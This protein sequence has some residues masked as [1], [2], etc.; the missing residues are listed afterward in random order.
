MAR[1]DRWQTC[2]CALAMVGALAGVDAQ[3]AVVINEQQR[4][5]TIEGF[6]A[7]PAHDQRDFA[8]PQAVVASAVNDLGLSILRIVPYPIFQ[9]T[10]NSDTGALDMSRYNLSAPHVVT[11]FQVLRR[12]AAA[13]MTRVFM[14]VFTPPAW[15]KQGPFA[16]T[17]TG[18]PGECGGTLRPD[19]YDVFAMYYAAWIKAIK[20]ETGIDVY[21]I[22]PENEPAWQQWY[23]SCVYSPTQMRDVIKALGRRFEREGIRTKII[24]AEDVITNQPYNYFGATM[25]DT[26]AARYMQ[27]LALHAYENNGVTPTSPSAA[28]WSGAYSRAHPRGKAIWMTET[29]GYANTWAD[30]LKYGNGIYTALKYGRIG[31]WSYWGVNTTGGHED[32]CYLVGN[33]PRWTYY[34]AKHYSRWV[35]PGAVMIDAA[36]SDTNVLSL[37][38]HHTADSTLTVILINTA[39]SARTVTLS[40]HSLP[41][42]A[43]FRSS[44]TERC[45]AAGAVGPGAT[46]SLPASSYTTLY[47]QHWAGRTT[48][49]A[50]EARAAQS[51]LRAARGAV[52]MHGLDGRVV[53]GASAATPGTPTARVY[54]VKWQTGRTGLV[55]GRSVGR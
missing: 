16:A 11:M 20:Q 51:G 38:F 52:R 18:I 29:S 14:S 45:I 13:G 21:A 35:R 55:F 50:P 39:S 1:R 33:E 53:R 8:C 42:F 15:M 44:A 9:D 48:A 5:Q 19:T 24:A 32:M 34:T 31:V 40:G 26:Q 28:A 47:G 49:A 23:H 10:P 2:G 54:A 6:G 7:A 12:Y 43:Q 46:V 17:C 22:S 27:V 30:A 4:Y 41:S 25:A 36:S 37:A 3:V